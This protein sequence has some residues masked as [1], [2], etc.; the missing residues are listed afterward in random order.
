MTLP[1][2]FARSFRVRLGVTLLLASCAGIASAAKPAAL[3]AGTFDPPRAAPE[4]ALQSSNGGKLRL[5]DYRG[6]V[7]LVGFG[8]SSCPQVCP[9]TL[10]VLAQARKKLGARGKQVQVIYVTVDPGRDDVKRMRTFVRA[11][12]PD[13][14]GGTGT[15]AQLAAV[16]KQYGVTAERKPLGKG[17]SYA[18]SSSVYLIDRKGRLRGM[19]PYG[20]PPQDFLHDMQALL[21]E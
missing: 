3:K 10:S 11:F 19:L 1:Q 9:T 6:K 12:D 18:H 14:V 8:F 7:V 15:E 2:R 4:L 5:A 17:Y 13:F 21:A 16:R 20:R